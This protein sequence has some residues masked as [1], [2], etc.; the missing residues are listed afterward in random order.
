MHNVCIPDLYTTKVKHKA[1]RDPRRPV[2]AADQRTVSRSVNRYQCWVRQST[3]LISAGDQ[4]A[5]GVLW[6]PHWS[7]LI[8]TDLGCSYP[9]RYRPT[10]RDR[11]LITGRGGY[12]MR[13]SWVGNIL[14]PLSRQGRTFGAPPYKEWKLFAPPFNITNT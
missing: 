8:I 13:K 12:K 11:T 6:V 1:M 3:C 5:I 4:R 2:W 10:I 14:R 7:Y 9:R